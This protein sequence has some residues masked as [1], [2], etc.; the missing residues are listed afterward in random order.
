MNRYLI[1]RDYGQKWRVYDDMEKKFAEPMD[2]A[3]TK[4][5]ARERAQQLND[6]PPL[7]AGPLEPEAA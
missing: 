1:A 5:A 6:I 3:S 4:S 7:G 2:T